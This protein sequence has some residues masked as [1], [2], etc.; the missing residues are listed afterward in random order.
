MTTADAAAGRRGGTA[1]QAAA[2]GPAR[3][4]P[5]SS[6][7]A[8]S[9]ARLSLSTIARG[10]G[11]MAVAGVLVN[12]GNLAVNLGTARLLSPRHYGTSVALLSCFLLL[13]MLGSALQVGVVRRETA[14]ARSGRVSAKRWVRTLRRGCLV[15]VAVCAVVGVAVREPLSRA[16]RLPSSTGVAEMLVCVALWVLLCLERGLL[17]ARHAY[18]VLARNI[19]LEG[20][21]RAVAMVALVAAFGLQGVGF[22]LLLSLVLGIVTAQY[23]VAKVPPVYTDPRAVAADAEPASWRGLFHDTGTAI[24]ALV[25]LAAL[26]NIDVLIVARLNPDMAGVY[27][28]V[29][30]TAKVPVFVGLAVSNYL[31][32]EAARRRRAGLPA[33]RQLALALIV[34][35]GPGMLL[36]LAALAQGHLVMS[37]VFGPDLAVGANTL[38]ALG[39]A[40]TFLATTLLFTNYLLGMGQRR[41]VPLLCAGVGVTWAAL[42]FMGGVLGT[43]CVANLACQALLAGGALLFVLASRPGQGATGAEVAGERELELEPA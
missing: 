2:P 17:Q 16:L 35:A 3:A 42:V 23:A 43:T 13:S 25:P 41:I 1:R 38:P 14:R 37:L 18:L 33:T 7:S 39:L 24:A 20:I 36:V 34:V 29:S 26:Q 11:A 22:G 21:A 4:S 40:M 9:S 10:P 12:V 31:L 8:A 30:T 27:A 19:A 15:G 6:A 5:A 32:P 28:A